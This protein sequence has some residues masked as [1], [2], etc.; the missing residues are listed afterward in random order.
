MERE[1]KRK[2]ASLCPHPLHPVA[3]EYP[4]PAPNT[5]SCVLRACRVSRPSVPG[6]S[7]RRP[8][9]PH[10]SPTIA[11]PSI[12][13]S[14]LPI[15]GAP[16]YTAGHRCHRSY[17]LHFLPPPSVQQHSLSLYLYRSVRRICFVGFLLQRADFTGPSVLAAYIRP[18]VAT[19][20]PDRYR[21]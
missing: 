16:L 12:S 7:V 21:K 15:S 13:I 3:P 20:K 11:R 1:E 5:A 10:R 19:S 6:L 9:S 17:R 4:R 14:A 8:P 18:S 2:L